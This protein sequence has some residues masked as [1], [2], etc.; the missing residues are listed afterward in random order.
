MKF[1]IINKSVSYVPQLVI[2]N[3]NETILTSLLE[4]F[5]SIYCVRSSSANLNN[6]INTAKKYCDRQ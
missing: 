2:M 3:N 4:R 5:D 1:Q 6:Q